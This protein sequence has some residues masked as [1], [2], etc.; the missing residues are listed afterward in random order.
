[1]TRTIRI[2]AEGIE[3]AA[4]LH[5]AE[6]RD[7]DIAVIVNSAM[8]MPRGFYSQFA[9]F[10]ARS[11]I[12][13]LTW[14]YRGVG[15]SLNTS[16]RDTSAYLHDWGERDLP[17]VIEWMQQRY[18]EKRLVIIAHS[19]GGQI[20]GMTEKSNE[21]DKLILIAS[22][23]GYWRLWSGWQQLRIGFIWHLIIPLVS[24]LC[25]YFPSRWFGLGVDLPNNVARQ[26]ARWGRDPGYLMGRHRRASADNFA[27]IDRPL[28]SIWI[29]DDD[30]AS[31][32]ANRK[33]LEWY[34]NAHI[35]RWDIAPRDLGVAR[36]GHFRLFR[37]SPGRKLWP[38]LVHWIRFGTPGSL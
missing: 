14:D 9:E 38:R 35:E 3:L 10:L 24:T 18:P 28:L 23:S 33:M 13:T 26:W 11:G 4:T 8:G 17:A 36:I 25:G 32:A 7:G 34:C 12:D 31:Y 20:I 30:I 21:A 15:E 19:V 22:Q 37:E 27:R 5:H 6:N 2:P 16:V 1:M 29:S